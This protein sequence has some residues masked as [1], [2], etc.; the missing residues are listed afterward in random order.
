MSK[1]K[2][3][4]DVDEII[5]RLA[6]S[7]FQGGA[8]G[9]ILKTF[10][11]PGYVPTDQTQLRRGIYG[12]LA[13]SWRNLTPTQK[14][15]WV[16]NSGSFPST[17]NFFINVNIN[18]ILINLPAITTFTPA[19]APGMMQVDFIES[20]PATMGAQVTSGVSIVPAGTKMLFYATMERRP[21]QLFDNPSMYQ[22]IA[23]YPSGTDFSTPVNFL[24]PWTNH[25]GVNR[26][27][28]RICIKNVLINQSN[29]I[30]SPEYISCNV[31]E[32]TGNFIQDI[33]NDVIYES[34]GTFVIWS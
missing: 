23:V 29:G 14:Q 20:T 7:I 5:G 18:L 3:T 11:S 16:D 17:L 26:L 33:N 21:T 10:K 4:S 6:G 2:F 15:T 24:N 9:I 34:P 22:P 8:Y 25:Y 12:Y 19:A 28:K 30:R 31:S 13:G 27:D 1:I 32:D